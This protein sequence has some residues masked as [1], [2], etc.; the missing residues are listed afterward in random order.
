MRVSYFTAVIG[1]AGAGWRAIDVDVEDVETLDE[2]GEILRG[3]AHADECV[4]AVLERED[5]WFALVR[6]DEEDDCRAFVSDLSATERSHYADLL[7]PLADIDLEDYK[8]L[9]VPAIVDGGTARD[10]AE[11]D[12]VFVGSGSPLVPVGGGLPGLGDVAADDALVHDSDDD[13]AAAAVDPE[14]PPAW[15]GDPGL[16]ADLGVAPHELVSLVEENQ[17]D[18]ASVIADVGERCGFVELLDAMR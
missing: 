11:D 13:L 2:M 4:I 6:V 12:G 7:A 1:S 10:E 3:V 14:L 8:D 15:A 16:L 9:R 5:E 18:P 17:N